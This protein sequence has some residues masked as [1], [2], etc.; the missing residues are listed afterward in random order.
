MDANHCWMSTDASD[1]SSETSDL[2]NS[3]PLEPL[4]EEN[5]LA[6]EDDR[7]PSSNVAEIDDVIADLMLIPKIPLPDN[8]GFHESCLTLRSGKSRIMPHSLNQIGDSA[9]SE[10]Y[11]DTVDAGIDVGITNLDPTSGLPHLPRELGFP[12]SLLIHDYV[13]APNQV[14]PNPLIPLLGTC[15][16]IDLQLMPHDTPRD[17]IVT[18][19]DVADIHGSRENEFSAHIPDEP[20]SDHNQATENHTTQPSSSFKG[21]WS[22]LFA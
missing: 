19:E 8:L 10:A 2:G 6:S 15:S 5:E 1:V 12:D 17:V 9:S 7:C 21:K 11:I 22:N 16:S 13:H 3:F 14:N 18:M 20:S 4:E